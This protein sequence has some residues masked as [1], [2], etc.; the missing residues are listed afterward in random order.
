ME[1]WASRYRVIMLL[2]GI[3]LHPHTRVM[4]RYSGIAYF[5]NKLS[6]TGSAMYICTRLINMTAGS[7]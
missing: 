3:D 5:L 4:H 7:Y 6:I 2:S 1:L